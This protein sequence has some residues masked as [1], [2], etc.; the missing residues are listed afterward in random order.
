[1]KHDNKILILLTLWASAVLVGC[2]SDNVEKSQPHTWH[3]SIPTT[4]TDGTTRTMLSVS[5]TTMSALWNTTDEVQV[6]KEGLSVGSVYPS[7]ASSSATL[8]G[9][10]T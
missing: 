6:Y 1:M 4:H 3:V 10:L 9:T 2:S 5:G 8:A 7:T